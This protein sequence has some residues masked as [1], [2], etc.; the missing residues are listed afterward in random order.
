MAS[1]GTATGEHAARSRVPR[2]M[3]WREGAGGPPVTALLGEG[4]VSVL[5]RFNP[6]RA[7]CVGGGTGGGRSGSTQR[8]RAKISSLRSCPQGG[9]PPFV[10]SVGTPRGPFVLSV[11]TTPC[12]FVLSVGGVRAFSRKNPAKAVKPLSDSGGKAFLKYNA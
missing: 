10:L 2:R 9:A 6:G 4:E 3:P 7:E 1:S 8:A 11:G 5:R 12:R